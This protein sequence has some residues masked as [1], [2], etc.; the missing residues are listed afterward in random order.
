MTRPAMN[1]KTTARLTRLR[2]RGRTHRGIMDQMKVPR[3]AKMNQRIPTADALPI[4]GYSKRLA[5]VKI[6]AIAM[7]KAQ[8]TA[9]RTLP[10]SP[11]R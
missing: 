8:K 1:E 6:V 10:E 2:L 7:S 11:S 9:I 5:P 4:A 3:T